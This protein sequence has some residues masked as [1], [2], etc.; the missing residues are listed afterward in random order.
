MCTINGMTFRAPP[1]M[2]GVVSASLGVPLCRA[3]NGHDLYITLK[4][5]NQKIT[6]LPTYLPTHVPI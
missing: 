4:T 3:A 1:C 5:A 6:Y 2:C